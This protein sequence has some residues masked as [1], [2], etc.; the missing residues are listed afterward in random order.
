MFLFKNK[1]L[2][3]NH[4]TRTIFKTKQVQ[5]EYNT[6]I[7]F[8]KHQVPFPIEEKG[9]IESIYLTFTSKIF[10]IFLCHISN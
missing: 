10:S 6:L 3:Q 9:A 8:K 2:H 4:L 7:L 5:R 1:A